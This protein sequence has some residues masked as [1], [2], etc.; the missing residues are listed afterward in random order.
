MKRTIV[1]IALAVTVGS[2]SA[3]IPDS[4]WYFNTAESGRGFNIEIQ[5]NTL[6]MA[7]FLYD[8]A[9]KPIWVFSGGVMSSDR[10]YSGPAFQTANGQALGGSYHAQTNVPFGNANITFPTTTTANITV[11][12]FTFTVTRELFGF[13]F[14]STTQPLLGEIAFLTGT[15]TSTF[16]AYFGERI[17]LTSTQTI[18]GT[19]YAVGNRTGYTGA[20]S[21]ALGNFAPSLGKWTILIDSATSYWDFYTFVF[22]GLNLTEGDDYTYLKGSSPSGS[23]SVIGNRIRSAQAAAGG[24]APGVTKSSVRPSTVGTDSYAATRVS[25]QIAHQLEPSQM[26]T[27]RAMENAPQMLRQ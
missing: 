22:D 11:N 23:L 26:E 13:D 25:A 3:A 16:P 7:G 15:S 1:A 2:A 20:S 24:N 18:N 12:G 9:G 5:N 10:T 17:S 19:V 4:G 6:F 14:T 8:A 21:L 27:L